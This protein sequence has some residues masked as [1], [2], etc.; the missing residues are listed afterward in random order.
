MSCADASVKRSAC[1]TAFS[2]TK[3][4]D[5]AQ[6]TELEQPASRDTGICGSN[7]GIYRSDPGPPPDVNECRAFAADGIA[8]ANAGKACAL[9]GSRL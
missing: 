4:H 1:P 8:I 3:Y 7:I 9:S 5:S 6:Q 2:K